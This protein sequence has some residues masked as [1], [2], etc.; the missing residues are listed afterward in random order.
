MSNFPCTQCGLCCRLVSK[1]L[2]N[3]DKFTFSNPLVKAA[4]EAFP[5]KTDASGACEMLIDNKCS[6]YDNRPLV[7]DIDKMAPLYGFDKANYYRMSAAVC[8]A[9]IIENKLD[10][11]YLIKDYDL[12]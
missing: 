7:C 9:L 8:N 4:L 1:A 6:V 3:K 11:S 5:Y 12:Q 2:A 10:E